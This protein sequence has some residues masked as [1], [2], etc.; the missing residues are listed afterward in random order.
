M[1]KVKYVFYA[2]CAAVIFFIS[3]DFKVYASETE[4][5]AA[6]KKLLKD[7][8]R[9]M[10]AKGSGPTRADYTEK[11]KRGW[12]P[13]IT[14]KDVSSAESKENRIII[15][16]GKTEG[17]PDNSFVCGLAG[18][19]SVAVSRAK[20]GEYELKIPADNENTTVKIWIAA[21]DGKTGEKEIEIKI[22]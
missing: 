17:V 1:K 7:N 18:N 14:V 5:K 22:K 6:D 3:A 20:N 9:P 21:P 2:L 8:V 10:S 13:R 12:D 15:I 11:N 4:D 16:K 19:L